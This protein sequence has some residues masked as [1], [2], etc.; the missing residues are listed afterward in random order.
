MP[1]D[2]SRS[3]PPAGGMTRESSDPVS[4][5]VRTYAS[6]PPYEAV[7]WDAMEARIVAGSNEELE[8]RRVAASRGRAGVFRQ[9]VTAW[10]E[11][12]AGWARPA[13]A[14]AVAA[15]AVA[16]ALVVTT[17]ATSPSMASTDNS[18]TTELTSNS[19]AV[20]AVILGTESNASAVSESNPISRDSLFSTLVDHR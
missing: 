8:R 3:A 15:V 11:V 14:A 6:R 19:D 9:R 20:D 16:T 12:T 1:N 18:A 17:P 10:W 7:N 4:E 5:L 2:R 13:M